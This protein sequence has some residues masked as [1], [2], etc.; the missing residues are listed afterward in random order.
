L[1]IGALAGSQWAGAAPD[2][3]AKSA[4]CGDAP[5][6]SPPESVVAGGR[7]RQ[8]I[9][10]IPPVYDSA[11]PHDLVVAFHGRT[12]PAE[13]VRDYFDLEPHARKPTLFVYPRGLAGVTPDTRNWSDPGDP[14]GRLRDY[15]LF[16]AI[17][18]RIATDYCVDPHR[19]FAVGH[20]LGASF[21]NSLGCARGKA[22]RGIATVAGAVQASRC[23]G[24][25]AALLI[26][27]PRDRLV[28]FELGTSVRDLNRRS[29][30][31]TGV[32]PAP[33]ETLTQPPAF[34]C[35]RYGALARNPVLW[36]PH[37]AD[38]NRH[39]RNYPHQWPPGTGELVMAFF[40][41]LH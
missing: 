19:V 39:G 20:S 32:P 23:S 14:P 8:L 21:V 10:A 9:L 41:R 29:N 2:P 12:S 6:R 13:Q 40:A 25:T 27:N 5:P 31:L 16:D 15:A 30:G 28:P 33:P 26:H 1:V 3:P 36:C 22:L 4:G 35:E 37:S 11:V 24:E 18:A 38:T 34:D 17:L 7:S